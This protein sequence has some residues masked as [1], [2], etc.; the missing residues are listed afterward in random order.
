M[1][2]LPYV[3]R[4][5]FAAG[6]ACASLPLLAPP[7][8]AQDI[9]R[10][11][12]TIQQL[13]A[14]EFHGRGYVNQGEQLAASYL[15]QRFRELGLRPLSPDY[16]QPFTLP[17]NTFPG[18]A[19]LKVDKQTLRPGL[20][21]IADPASGGGSIR[22]P[23]Y[24]LDSLVFSQTAARQSLLATRLHKSVLVLTQAEVRRLVTL[25]PTV[26][27]HL[28]TAAARIMLVPTKL[29]ASQSGDQTRQPQLEV[30]ASSWPAQARTVALQL[31]A[32]LQ[33]AYPTQNVI[34]Y[35]PGTA[36]PDSFLLVS[37]HYDHLGQL[38]RCTYFPGAN[39]NA[40]GVAMLL[41]LAAYYA[42]PENRPAYS[43]AFIAFGAEEAGL[44][45]SRYF[46]E[47][48]LIPLPQILFVVNL[49]L[50]GT[51]GEGLT[52]VNGRIFEAQF[53]QLQYL[54][55]QHHYVTSIAARGRAANSDHFFF[56]EHGVPAF[57]LYTRGGITAYHD[58]LDRPETLP[59]T[60][61]RSVFQLLR[62]FLNE[63]GASPE[64]P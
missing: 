53:Q 51:G 21:F 28:A 10:A 54:N 57:F 16:R 44:I 26:Q 19:E 7:V 11:R 29:T 35:L 52:V 43:V 9:A 48:P 62:D 50:L 46:V 23:V 55:A 31:D 12:Q 39:D 47:H 60:A 36:R 22:G 64:H 6:L 37:A 38:G 13:T 2:W 20:D 14:P 5:F 25:P 17:I 49:D 59:L 58:V 4:P 24:R 18:R 33:P 32:C 41:E 42:H 56:S 3:L 40:S 63:Q 15:Q 34:G 61:F 27:A 8:Q 1:N 30:L 45:G